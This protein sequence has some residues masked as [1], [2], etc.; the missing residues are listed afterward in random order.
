[1]N[2]V[3][4]TNHVPPEVISPLAETAEVLLGPAGGE[5]MPRA[6]VLEIGPT[7]DAIINQTELRVDSELLDRC[8]RLRV[9]ANVAA[10]TDNLDLPLMT[11]RGVWATNTPGV[12]CQATADLTLA[13]LLCLARRVLPADAYVRSGRWAKFQPGTWDGDLLAG[14]TLGIIGYGNIGRAVAHRARAFG[15]NIVFHRRSAASEAGYRSLED[16]LAE[17]DYVTLHLPLTPETRGLMNRQRFLQMKRGACF[18]NLARGKVMVEADLVA[19]LSSGHL[20]GAALDVFEDE[21]KVHPA[22]LALPN[23]VLAPHMGGGTHQSRRAAR[24]LAVENVACVL[25]GEPPPTPVNRPV[26][27]GRK[28]P[29]DAVEP[30]G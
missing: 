7:L 11:A 23:V 27:S 30:A 24:D 28:L 25:R 10:G 3:L 13:F 14:R 12:F 16:L 15:M 6:A 5:L 18:L 2:R 22:L 17:S 4:I 20:A 8:R 21:P 19:A 26:A 29:R 9:V 1:M